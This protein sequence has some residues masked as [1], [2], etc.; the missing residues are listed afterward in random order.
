MNTRHLSRDM[1]N[2]VTIKSF[3]EVR[4]VTT[5]FVVYNQCRQRKVCTARYTEC[6]WCSIG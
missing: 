2:L 4:R 5:L 1:V 6:A 3:E